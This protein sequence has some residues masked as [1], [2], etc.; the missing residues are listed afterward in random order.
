M[1]DAA[2]ETFF[3]GT[4]NTFRSQ[5]GQTIE[6]YGDLA[7]R[8]LDEAI[9]D[10]SANVEVVEEALRFLGNLDDKRTHY[11]RLA[12]LLQALSS[13]NP[14][15]R[16]AASVGLA[17]LGDPAAKDSICAAIAR[18]EFEQLRSNLRSALHSL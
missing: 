11:S 8:T 17:S 3:D 15:V 4:D 1:Q 16:D 12:V 13:R 7:V 5:A 6:F 2:Q 9:A 14:R 10:S 18:E